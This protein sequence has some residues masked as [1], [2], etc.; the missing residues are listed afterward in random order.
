MRTRK[1][2]GHPLPDTPEMK[3]WRKEYEKMSVEE[4]KAK[5][6]TLGLSEEEIEE[7]IKGKAIE[8]MQANETQANEEKEV[9]TKKT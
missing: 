1:K 5:L 6:R 2:E 3:L 4:H 7:V 9:K 8:D